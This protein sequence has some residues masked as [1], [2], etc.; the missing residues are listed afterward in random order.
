MTTSHHPPPPV[1]RGDTPPA[2]DSPREHLEQ[3]AQA[4][5]RAL[6][7]LH[8]AGGQPRA[9]RR[10]EI[11]TEEIRATLERLGGK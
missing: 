11:S 2:G 4:L 6:H 10:I 3:A 1:P 7:H 8:N 9:A 5:E